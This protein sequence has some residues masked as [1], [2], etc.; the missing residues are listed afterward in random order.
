MQ[1]M[2]QLIVI[3]GDRILRSKGV[4]DFHGE[5]RRF[6][7][8]GVQTVLDGDVQEV[9]PKGPRQSRLILIGRELNIDALQTGWENCYAE[10]MSKQ[11]S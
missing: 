5:T 7:F 1:W 11:I 2:Q 4:L 8:H 3:Y 6:V 9:W 10:L